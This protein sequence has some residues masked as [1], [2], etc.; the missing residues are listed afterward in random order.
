MSLVKSLK[1]RECPEEYEVSPKYVCDMCFGPLEINYHWDRIK[2]SVDKESIIKGPNSMW[3]YKSF[4][5]IDGEDVVDIGTGF[6]P[7]LPADNLSDYLGIKKLWIKNDAVNPTYSFKDRVVSVASTK[8][9]EFNFETFA[10]AST[11]NLAGSVAAHGAKAGFR[12]L[13][14]IPSDLEKEKIVA[15]S[16]Y[17]P[18]VVAIRGN[19]DDVNR[20]CTQLAEIKP[21]AFVNINL[22]PF[23][24]EGSK[25]VGFEVAEQLGWRLPDHLIAPV[26][27]GSLFI[28]VWKGFEE[29]FKVGLIQNPVGT[30]MHIA[31]PEGCSPVTKAFNEGKTHPMPVRPE[32][33]AKSLAIGNPADGYYA[34]KLAKDTKGSAHGV[35]DTKIVEGISLLARTEG[36][37]TE[38][39]GGV[40]IATLVK[41]V[42]Q[43]LI[44]KDEEVVVLITGNGLKTP[45]VVSSLS[46]PTEIDPTV[47]SFEDSFPNY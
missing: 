23:Y 4:L 46:V 3:R 24:S 41:M 29:F 13:V 19:Y 1:C 39:A 44:S 22:R 5:P 47:K 6:T 27:S 26:A 38:T 31:Q 15:A 45:E 21:W 11:G 43:G 33:I 8:A 40:V 25:T 17:G 36:I 34:I 32:T 18:E 20:L 9:K 2:E 12:T 28:K 35:S 16:I 37:F 10:C 42:K 7:L 30:R 14:F